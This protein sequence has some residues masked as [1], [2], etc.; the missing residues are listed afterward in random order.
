[1]S[2]IDA[3][4]PPDPTPQEQRQLLAFV[5]PPKKIGEMTDDELFQFA[6]SLIL[7]MRERMESLAADPDA[8]PPSPPTTPG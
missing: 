3:T 5:K 6:K 1:L 2:E 7:L 8:P 4:V